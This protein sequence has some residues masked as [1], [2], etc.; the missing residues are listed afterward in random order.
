MT[1]C[2]KSTDTDLIINY[3]RFIPTR[4]KLGLVKIVVA[5]LY[6]IIN[7]WTGFHNNMQKSKSILQKSLFP[8]EL[9]NK[10]VKNYLRDQ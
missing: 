10:F 8:S 5:S 3:F 4:K 2:K 9:W 7:T 6:K 1:N